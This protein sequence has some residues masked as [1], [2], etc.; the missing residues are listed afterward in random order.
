MSSKAALIINEEGITDNSTLTNVG[1][2]P[3][4]DVTDFQPFKIAS[5][6]FL[7]IHVKNPKTYLKKAKNSI[8]RQS[9]MYNFNHYGSPI[10]INT[11]SLSK[12]IEE[13]EQL[14]LTASEKYS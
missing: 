14:L 8:I 12:K 1:F 9:L 6:N 3:W 11:S 2:I 13:I 10:A 4:K 5:N 7:I